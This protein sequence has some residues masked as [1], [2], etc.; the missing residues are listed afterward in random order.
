M[1]QSKNKISLGLI[2]RLLIIGICILSCYQ[3][4]QQKTPQTKT[5]DSLFSAGKG[6][7]IWTNSIPDSELIKGTEVYNDGMINNVSKPTITIYSP[8]EKNTGTAIIVF[9]GGGYNKLA[10]NLE[11]SEVCEWLASIGV[12]GILLKYRVPASGPHHDKDCKGFLFD[13]LQRSGR[14]MVLLV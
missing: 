7:P 1:A 9:P 12:T 5:S 4:R 8:K 11:G 3:N 10:I 14:G 6:M 13:E 2:F